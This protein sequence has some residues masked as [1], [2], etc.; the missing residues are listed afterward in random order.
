MGLVAWVHCAWFVL[1]LVQLAIS[2]WLGTRLGAFAVMR[3]L[4]PT[5]L[6]GW[7]AEWLVRGGAW[8]NVTTLVQI[9]TSRTLLSFLT[10]VSF[11]LPYSALLHWVTPRFHNRVGVAVALLGA[12]AL[13]CM[14]RLVHE[15]W[16][17]MIQEGLPPPELHT[18]ACVVAAALLIGAHFL[19]A[20]GG[21]AG[22]PAQC[23]PRNVAT[24]L[25]TLAAILAF[26]D[27]PERLE[28]PLAWVLTSVPRLTSEL[29]AGTHTANG[30][31][32][33]RAVLAG[34]PLGLT[35][36]VTFCVAFPYLT[37]WT[38]AWSAYALAV[39]LS[40][41]SIVPLLVHLTA[42]SAGS[43]LLDRLRFVVFR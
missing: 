3:V 7:Y 35:P 19:L 27:D 16:N 10:L 29:V 14:L 22:A 38:D 32:S 11:A 13:S 18:V 2:T 12:T 43:R 8:G 6:F 26:L 1:V 42:R 39:A 41:G 25:I 40:L 21:D 36:Y 30:P 20:A 33:A 31:R 34:L 9:E 24:R 5:G 17:R 37:G 23:S 4:V 28:T 15:P